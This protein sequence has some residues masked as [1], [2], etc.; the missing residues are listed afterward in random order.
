MRIMYNGHIIKRRCD[1]MTEAIGTF[2][3]RLKQLR[4]Q[5][6]M[7]QEELGEILGVNKATISRYENDKFEINF[8]ST[9]KIAEVFGVTTDYLMGIEQNTPIVPVETR[10]IEEVYRAELMEEINAIIIKNEITEIKALKTIVSSNYSLVDFRDMLLNFEKIRG[11][12]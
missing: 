3:Y 7:K 2:G 5:K 9:K 10:T 4:K 6:G 8:D 1:Y 11:T 12:K